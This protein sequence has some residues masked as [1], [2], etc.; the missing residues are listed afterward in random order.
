MQ[1]LLGSIQ[2][3]DKPAFFPLHKTRTVRECVWEASVTEKNCNTLRRV[4][5]KD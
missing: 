4:I 1:H 3:E 2:S 5:E